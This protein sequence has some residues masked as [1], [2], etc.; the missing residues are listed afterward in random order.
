MTTSLTKIP[1]ADPLVPSHVS[2][3]LLS[4]L[5]AHEYAMELERDRWDFAVEI[6][7]L[8][9]L[10]VTN[11]DLRW[12]VCKR[13]VKHA[14]DVTPVEHDQ[15]E[16]QA[17]GRLNFNE[18]TCFVLTKA[19]IQLASQIESRDASQDSSRSADLLARET[20][21]ANGRNN[22]RDGVCSIC[23]ANRKASESNGRPELRPDAPCWDGRLHELRLG[24]AL[25]KVFRLPSPNQEAVLLAF[26]EEGWPP[27]IDDPLPPQ[28]DMEPKRRLHDT[29]KSLN[30]RQKKRLIRF[31]GDGTGEG[32][33]WELRS[34]PA[35]SKPK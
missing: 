32:I 8:R 10:G 26:Q 28:G 5:R 11:S 4:L 14:L 9:E 16:F 27:R 13:Y 2:R 19:G 15:R 18:Q 30:R 33:R 21:F 25:V 3:G 6:T 23:G 1:A 35:N 17:A 12:L 31:M 29:I 34:E 7:S 22:I 24:Q 20:G